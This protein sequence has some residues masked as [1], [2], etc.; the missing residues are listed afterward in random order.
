MEIIIKLNMQKNGEAT[1]EATE[2][3]ALTLFKQEHADLLAKTKSQ[4]D[5]LVNLMG[6]AAELSNNPEAIAIEDQPAFLADLYRALMELELSTSIL[7]GLLGESEELMACE[8]MLDDLVE[9]CELAAD[10]LNEADDNF[11]VILFGDD[12]DEGEPN[13][14]ECEG[15]DECPFAAAAEETE[16]DE[17]PTVELELEGDGLTQEALNA[18]LQRDDV[19][20]AVQNLLDLI[21]N[22]LG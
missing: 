5:T 12:E 6:K 11:G 9:A 14:E 2:C 19:N 18:L 1:A 21:F 10:F 20:E 17:G 4:Y 3:P 16:E 15:R 8:D 22:N 13:C 7:M